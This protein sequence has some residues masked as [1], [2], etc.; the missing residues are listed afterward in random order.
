MTAALITPLDQW[1]GHTIGLP[2]DTRLS[3]HALEAYQLAALNRTL[4]HVHRHSP[5]YRHRSGGLPSGPLSGL[6]DLARLP[7]TTDG[8]I[9]KEPLAFLCVSQDRVARAVTLKTSG[10]TGPPKRLFFTAGDQERTIDFFHHGMTTLVQ[11]GQRALILMPG[12]APGSVGDLLVKGLAKIPAK[13]IVHGP[14]N[15]PSAAIRQAL[16]KKVDCLVGIPVQILA[17]ACHP[18]GRTLAHQIRSVLLS[19]DYVPD[20][21]SARIEE[22][23]Q[24]R[25]FR[26]YG[27]TEMGLGG[28]VE[29]AAHCGCH[30]REA[31]LLVEIID[32]DTGQPPVDGT[33][34]EIVFTTLTREAMPLVRYRTGDMALFK[35]DPCPCGTVLK[36]MD[37]FRGRLK[38]RPLTQKGQCLSIVDLDEAIFGIEGVMN[39][40]AELSRHANT[41]V[42]T[43]QVALQASVIPDA[44]SGRIRKAVSVLPEVH[45]AMADGTLD[46]HL[47]WIDVPADVSTG[48]E[49]RRIYN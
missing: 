29:C 7:F 41:D 44:L 28:G 24:C 43:L 45:G 9:R 26:H 31:D 14:V 12:N 10:T 27:M 48:A 35:V 20:A 16:E 39:Y 25:V 37:G 38:G 32:P 13:G 15:D 17:M 46:L 4:M 47:E 34:G 22:R 42:L 36:T 6:A 1:I 11:P 33:V 2:D 23:W 21:L 8:D 5:F 18:H 30:F 40:R 3:R 49:K 19:T